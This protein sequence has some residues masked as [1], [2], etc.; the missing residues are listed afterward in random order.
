MMVVAVLLLLLLSA[1]V[2]WLR[3]LFSR[4]LLCP[5]PPD[6][7]ALTAL[8]KAVAPA[9]NVA[10]VALPP[11][12]VVVVVGD[13]PPVLAIG[14][15]GGGG[16]EATRLRQWEGGG[17]EPWAQDARRAATLCELP[18]MLRRVSSLPLILI[19]QVLL[20]GV[21]ARGLRRVAAVGDRALGPLC[22]LEDER[23]VR[24]GAGEDLVG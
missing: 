12:A 13:P 22:R 7:V 1:V 9:L 15:G 19:L 4:R 3:P 6:V 23:G 18:P 20:V 2:E 11:S 14:A 10:V 16:G 21:R 5:A 24:V 8:I 17:L